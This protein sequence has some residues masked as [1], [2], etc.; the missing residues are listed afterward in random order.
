[1][2]RALYGLA[3][4]ARSGKDTFAEMLWRQLAILQSVDGDTISGSPL[5]KYAFA[6]PLKQAASKMFGIPLEVF[7]GGDEREIVD[8]FWGFSPRE[9]LQKLGTEGGREVFGYNMWIKRA[10]YQFKNS[11]QT[12]PFLIT[13]VRF[14]N[15]AEW[16]RSQGGKVIHIRREEV[17][18]DV[19]DHASEKGVTFIDGDIIVNNNGSL[20][21]LESAAF[22][23][24]EYIYNI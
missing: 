9:M 3:G 16:I 21:D 18:V 10:G 11:D 23:A 2:S 13:D 19:Q 5:E 12:C 4:L 7:Y 17:S 8:A 22:Y 1:M 20:D 6:D 14:D 15:E 24:A